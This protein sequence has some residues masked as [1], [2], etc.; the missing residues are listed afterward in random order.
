MR[1]HTLLLLSLFATPALAEA[2]PSTN[3][4]G[5]YLDSH[6]ASRL[7]D[8]DGVVDYTKA[9]LKFDAGNGLLAERLLQ[10]E[11][12]R[13]DISEAEGLAPQVIKTNS[14]QRTARLVLGLKDF[15][16]R[17]FADARANFNEAA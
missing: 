5:T 3:S 12:L 2:P 13:G 15:R 10:A 4:F 14:Q 8:L 17:R 11:I 9:A 7:N 16:N 6:L 1:L